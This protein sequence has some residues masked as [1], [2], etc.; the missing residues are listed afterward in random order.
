MLLLQRLLPGE[1]RLSNI[2]VMGMGEPLANLDNLLPAPTRDVF[3]E[4]TPNGFV[5]SRMTAHFSGLLEEALVYVKLCG[6]DLGLRWFRQESRDS[7]KN[8]SQQLSAPRTRHRTWAVAEEE[9]TDF[10]MPLIRS[11]FPCDCAL[12]E[13]HECLRLF[14]LGRELSQVRRVVSRDSEHS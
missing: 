13:R 6:H 5:A 7:C 12:R 10:D 1:E 3:L 2:V 11:L 9:L 14:F 4:R 8:P